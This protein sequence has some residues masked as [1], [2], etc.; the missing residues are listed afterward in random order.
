MMYIA[1]AKR[2]IDTK[3][4]EYT[5]KNKGFHCTGAVGGGEGGR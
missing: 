2:A 3:K 1:A 5:N 4:T